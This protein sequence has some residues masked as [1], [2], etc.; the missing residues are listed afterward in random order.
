MVEIRWLIESKIDLEQIYEYISQDS[1]KYAYLQ[2]Q[3]LQ[4]KTQRLKTFPKIGKIV[5]EIENPNIRE[6]VYNNYRIISAP[7]IDVLMIYFIEEKTQ[8]PL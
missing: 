2:I 3:K 6:L 8:K 7:R 1:M 4:E 5:R